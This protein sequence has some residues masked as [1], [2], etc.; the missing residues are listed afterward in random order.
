[1]TINNVATVFSPN[2]FRPIDLTPND[3]IYAGNLV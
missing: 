1:M 3:L 2:I